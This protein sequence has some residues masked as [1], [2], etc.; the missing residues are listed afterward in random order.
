MLAGLTGSV[1]GVVRATQAEYACLTFFSRGNNFGGYLTDVQR[2]IIAPDPRV[3]SDQ[4]PQRGA[5]SPDGAHMA[6]LS[7]SGAGRYALYLANSDRSFGPPLCNDA[8]SCYRPAGPGQPINSSLTSE[9]GLAWSPDSSRVGYIWVDADGTLMAATARRDGV[10]SPPTHISASRGNVL[11]LHGWAA[12]GQHIAFS[13][14]DGNYG[15]LYLWNPDVPRITAVNVSRKGDAPYLA[16]TSAPHGNSVGLITNEPTPWLMLISPDKPKVSGYALL[17]LFNWNPVWSPDGRY[18]ALQYLDPPYWRLDMY[19]VDG[20]VYRD[21]G[22][23]EVSDDL[24]RR[25][26][27]PPLYWSADS[28]ALAYAR[29]DGPEHFKLRLFRLD[30]GRTRTVLDDLSDVPL[31]TPDGSRLI[32]TR[33]VGAKFVIGSYDLASEQFMPLVERSTPTRWLRWLPRMP[34]PTLIYAGGENGGLLDVELL[35]PTNGDR[36]T[37]AKDLL[38]A[39]PPQFE[40]DGGWLFWWRDRQGRGGVDGYSAQGEPLYRYSVGQWSGERLPQQARSP[41]AQQA[42][43]TL[44]TLNADDLVHVVLAENAY[45]LSGKA[46][47]LLTHL[48]G[49]GTPTW[50][51]DGK[52]VALVVMAGRQQAGQQAATL[53]VLAADG[54][55]VREYIGTGR[56]LYHNLQWSRCE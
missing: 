47:T 38:A 49:A 42:L 37:L 33:R 44:W 4:T 17:P 5:I 7:G 50:S 52:Q 48:D 54:S 30:T 46:T 13:L 20:T 32:V 16:Y 12:D 56:Y 1:L 26:G 51:P 10:Q 11:Q 22:G 23:V 27:Q 25:D 40:H 36:L 34:R 15:K 18:V 29:I 19:G 55:V 53:Q 21:V 9:S 14:F 41:D 2:G 6:Y 3:S 8:N 45:T 28:R 31:P 24:P 35:D 43:I 39:F